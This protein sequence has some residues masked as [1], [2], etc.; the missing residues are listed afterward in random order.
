M[1]VADGVV[2]AANQTEFNMPAG[3]KTQIQINQQG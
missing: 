1:Y 3:G 2:T